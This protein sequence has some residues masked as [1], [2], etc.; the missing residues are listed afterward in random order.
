MIPMR[1]SQ[2]LEGLARPD[3]AQ[4]PLLSGLCL[5]SRA[6]RPG[7]AFVALAG[8]HQHGISAA[9]DAV[10]RGAVA[11]LVETPAKEIPVLPVPVLGIADLRRHLGAIAARAYGSD[12]RR[13]RLIGITGTNGKTSCV[14]LLTQ[15]LHQAGLVAASSGTLG[16]GLFGALAPSERT[17][18]DLLSLHAGIAS[19][20]AQGATVMSMEVSS[21]ALDQG[22]VD[23]LQFEVAAFTNLSRDHLDYHHDMDA[24]L[25][26]KARL[27][28]WPGLHAAVINSDDPAGAALARD[29]SAARLI[30]TSAAGDPDATVAA[31]AL[32]TD[33]HGL[34][35]ELCVDGRRLPVQ[36]PLLG[37]FNVANLLT[38]SGILLAL[39]WTPEHIARAIPA[40]QP[41]PGRMSRLGGDGQ[42]PLVVVDYAHSP[43]A[44]DKA[45]A[46]LRE[47]TRGR[48]W[49]VFGCGG[50]R[51]RGK[52]A[53]MAAL[54]ERGADQIIVTDDNPRGEDGAAI[55][56]DILAG[57][58]HAGEILVE[59]DRR[60]AI[61]L[62]VARAAAN[63]TVLIAGKGHE[64]WQEV[65]ASKFPF[66]DLAEARD[67]LEAA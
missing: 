4:D 22:R 26:A 50:E 61:R 42:R 12:P 62:A 15:A 60:H 23:G 55:V 48:L 8:A 11:V 25:A 40:L 19:L 44:L 38:V 58:S 39:D 64:R 24:Y 65:G 36:S 56:N 45:L 3:P 10:A 20:R 29:C 37:R 54:A 63:D 14:Q 17:T 1:L 49:L 16:I 66:D 21:H 46:T 9:A 35:F 52:R 67:A 18:P 33:P 34:C 5:D 31:R 6:I 7:D 13:P 32:R 43:D 57:F 28:A 53:Q 27:F 59:R 30:R 41:V 51:D 2:L 47:H